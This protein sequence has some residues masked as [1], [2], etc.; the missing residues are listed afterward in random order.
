MISFCIKTDN[1]NCINYLL[2]SLSSINLENI[3]FVHKVFSKYNNIII[4]YLGSDTSL[5]YNEL[6]SV[7]CNCI[8]ENYESIIIH[9]LLLMNYFYFD[10]SDLIKIKNNCS[11]MLQKSTKNSLVQNS[12]KKHEPSNY[13]SDTDF[14][15]RVSLLWCDILHYITLNKSMILDGF[16]SFRIAD[17]IKLLDSAIDYSVNEFII[18]REY[19]EFIDLL[20]IYINSRPPE[21]DLV[22]LIYIN[23]E[24]ILLDQYKNIIS[25]THA[26]LDT[27]Y[28][29]DISFS[30]NDYALNSFLS[31][32]PSKIII[33]LIGQEDDFI[34]TLKLIFCNRITI[35]TDC[36]ICKTYKL[37]TNSKTK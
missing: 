16:I 5:F 2:T 36:N 27:H 37:I 4:H 30:S 31:L 26:N 9:N 1:K 10:E 15:S 11:L 23:G 29:S 24:S 13:L 19:S 32:L 17:Y 34:Q 14:S 3:V 18:N 12:V 28:L 8:L 35:C 33:H 6:S 20:K 21:I 7:I 25:V 22:H